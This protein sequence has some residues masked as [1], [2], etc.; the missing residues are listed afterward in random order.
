MLTHRKQ[1]ITGLPI[2]LPFDLTYLTLGLKFV[3][4]RGAMQVPGHQPPAAIGSLTYQEDSDEEPSGLGKL[5]AFLHAPSHPVD[6]DLS[7]ASSQS[8]F[9]L[10]LDGAGQ[11]PLWWGHDHGAHKQ[12]TLST[13]LPSAG[14]EPLPA[15]SLL[16]C[17]AATSSPDK[18]PA[19][20]SSTLP[21]EARSGAAAGGAS[22]AAPVMLFEGKGMS[23][24]SAAA[25]DSEDAEF[26]YAFSGGKREVS[27]WGLV[28]L[29]TKTG[30]ALM[31]VQCLPFFHCIAAPSASHHGAGLSQLL[32]LKNSIQCELIRLT[33]QI[34]LLELWAARIDC[35]LP[36]SSSPCAPECGRCC[37]TLL[38][39]PAAGQ[40]T[41]L[42]VGRRAVL[43]HPAGLPA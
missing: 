23:A 35:A 26:D 12:G 39:H 36:S 1:S 27:C 32:R 30:R 5:E 10:E 31:C 19:G 37:P 14:V 13:P 3:H 24:K 9:A 22:S 33:Q 18:R 38:P 11:L 20:T 28:L 16:P 42:V 8:E 34:L 29:G 2:G 7:R 15:K 43:L 6:A 40:R 17:C 21:P 41:H 25:E 4:G